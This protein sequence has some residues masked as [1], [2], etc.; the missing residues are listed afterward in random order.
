MFLDKKPYVVAELNSSHRGKTEIAKQMIVAA[1]EC[2]CNAVKFQSWTSESLYCKD[3]YEE[4]PISKRMVKSFSLSSDKIKE[5]A[6]FC[7]EIGIDFS[8][9]P[10]SKEEVDFMVENCNPSFIKIASMDINNLPFL[11]HIARKNLPVVLSTGM[12]TVEEI[13][14]AVKAI[15]EEGN[16]SI[17]I[18]HCVSIYP[19]ECENVN[20]CNLVMLKERFPEYCVGYSDHTIGSEVA[21]ASIALG[22][23]LVEKHFT[24]DSSVIGWD[25]QMATEP[26]AMK[27]LVDSVNNVY[28]SLGKYDRELNA[29]EIEQRKKMRR[30]LIAACNIEKGRIITED[31]LDAKRPGTGISASRFYEF[32]G[33]KA[34]MDIEKDSLITEEDFE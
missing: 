32:V 22:A 20:L 8:S 6:D 9:T 26:E 11:K 3:Y 12:S 7:Q 18:L 23:V 4:N 25:N 34:I 16:N 24:L 21:C 28:S 10:Y 17:C 5:M 1:K 19:V 13:D 2:G 29:D 14:A 30:S 15:E 27:V 31:A 33:R